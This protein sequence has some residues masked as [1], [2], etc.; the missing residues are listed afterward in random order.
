[1]ARTKE[2]QEKLA[3]RSDLWVAAHHAVEA[4][5]LEYGV[6]DERAR[7]AAIDIMDDDLGTIIDEEGDGS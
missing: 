7:G 5:L 2:E 4:Y 6:R 3:R 1:M